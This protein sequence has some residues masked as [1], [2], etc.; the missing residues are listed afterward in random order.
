MS[1]IKGEFVSVRD[2]RVGDTVSIVT[3]IGDDTSITILNIIVRAVEEVQFG[4]YVQYEK[5]EFCLGTT[6][7]LPDTSIYRV[8]KAGENK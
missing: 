5:N 8:K 3:S 2:L 7:I 1:E 6:F 4:H